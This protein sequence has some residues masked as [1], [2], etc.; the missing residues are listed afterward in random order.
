VTGFYAGATPLAANLRASCALARSECDT[1]RVAYLAAI[2]AVTA[3]R[4]V[5]AVSAT[6]TG[7]F[8]GG[9]AGLD[10]S[11]KSTTPFVI[12]LCR[13]ESGLAELDLQ[14]GHSAAARKRLE[15]AVRQLQQ[16]GAV[17]LARQVERMCAAISD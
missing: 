11:E 17:V 3:M 1:A 10:S 8:A 2:D 6:A 13:A 16:A 4:P 12:E 9:G 15:M 5:A 14:D 7:G